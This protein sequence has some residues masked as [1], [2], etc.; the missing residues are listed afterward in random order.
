[1]HSPAPTAVLKWYYRPLWVLILLFLV[2]GPFGLPILWRSPGFSRPVKIVLTIL[3]LAY[4]ALLIEETIRV[5]RVIAS[6]MDLSV[7]DF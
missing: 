2:L 5:F 4:T 6:D 1:M 3:V 7:P